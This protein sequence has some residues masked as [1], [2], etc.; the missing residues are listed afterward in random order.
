MEKLLKSIT[1]I[2]LAFTLYIFYTGSIRLYD[3][4]TGLITAVIVGGS[5]SSFLIEDWRKSLDIKRIIVLIKYIIRYFFIDEVKAHIEVIRLGFS[6]RMPIKPGIVRI[7][8]CSRTDYAI[9]LIALSITNTPG[10]IVIDID[11]DK[12]FIYVNWINV[13]TVE[14]SECYRDIAYVFDS[15]AKKIFD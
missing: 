10:T 5:L 15:Y 13:K 2:L 6:P 12:G 7:P 9:M 4:V 3:I 1:P 11:K 8:I 14:P